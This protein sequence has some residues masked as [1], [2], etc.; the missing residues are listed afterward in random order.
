MLPRKPLARTSLRPVAS[1]GDA[2][3]R[4]GLAT[5]PTPARS[6]PIIPR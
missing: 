3:F 2:D 4:S 5:C 1:I 6:P